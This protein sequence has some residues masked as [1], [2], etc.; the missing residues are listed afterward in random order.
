N[1]RR[2]GLGGELVGE[3]LLEIAALHG[4]QALSAARE[5]RLPTGEVAPIACERRLRKAVLEPQ[6]I[7][8]RVDLILC[9]RACGCR[10]GAAPVRHYIF[11][12]AGSSVTIDGKNQIAS[13]ATHIRKNIGSVCRAIHVIWR[14][15]IPCRT[16]RLKPTGGV[17][18]AISTTSTRKTPNHRRAMPACSTVGRMTRIVSTTMEMPS[19]KHPSTM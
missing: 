5:P 15:V 7:A 16:N 12:C 3:P 17:I 14:P 19:R 6:S 13:T 4:E 10:R 8:E 1:R 9:P 2:L 18:C 11:M